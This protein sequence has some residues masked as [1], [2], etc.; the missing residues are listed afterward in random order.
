MKKITGICLALVLVLGAAMSA[1]AAPAN[2]G[3]PEFV[4]GTS[5]SASSLQVFVG[6]TVDLTATTTYTSNKANQLLYLSSENWT[7]VASSTASG[8]ALE[9]KSQFVST[10]TFSSD[11]PG[12]YTVMYSIVVKH[13]ESGKRTYFSS[14]SVTITVLA[15]PAPVVEDKAPVNA[16]EVYAHW[17]Q[18]KSIAN[19]NGQYSNSWYHAQLDAR[20]FYSEDEVIDFL[21]S[22]Y[23][24]H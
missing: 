17:K 9:R 2:A 6:E 13:D 15:R 1:W 22:I 19:G 14:S 20:T 21:D 10:A 18:G 12:E 8:A 24:P 16:R 11:V 7:N 5:L 3:A 4:V 23:I